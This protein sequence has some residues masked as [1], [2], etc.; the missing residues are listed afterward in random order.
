MQLTINVEQQHRSS[1]ALVFTINHL[2][3]TNK[4]IKT[5]AMKNKQKTKMGIK[6]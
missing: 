6:Q 4:K 3:G 1:V 5:M 2:T